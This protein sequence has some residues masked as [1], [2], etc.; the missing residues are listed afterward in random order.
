MSV[1]CILVVPIPENKELAKCTKCKR[2]L[3]QDNVWVCL[4]TNTF[5]FDSAWGQDRE[6]NDQNAKEGDIGVDFDWEDDLLV[7]RPCMEAFLG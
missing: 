5:T 2:E 3:H 4:K 7:C 6:A 1:N